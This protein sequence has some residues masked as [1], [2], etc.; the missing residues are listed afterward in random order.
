MSV[1]KIT[2]DLYSVGILNP[3]LRV[4][5][6]I[7]PTE[8]G[9]SYNAYLIKGEKTAL[10]EAVHEDYLDEFID[11]INQVSSLDE[12]DY[13]IVNHTEPDHSGS[14]L[15][16]LEQKPD[17]HIYCTL[18][19]QKY[20]KSMINHEFNSTIVKQGD[21]LDLGN[22]HVL[23]FIPA[24]FLH[25]PDTMFTYDRNFRVLFSCD[26]LSTHF[27]EPTM[28][29]TGVHYQEEYEKSIDHYFHSILHPFKPSVLAGLDKIKD[30]EL[31]FVCTSHG[32]VLTQSIGD[33]M[34]K[35]RQ[36]ATPREDSKPTILIAYASAYGYT[37]LLAEKA[38]EALIG[39][40]YSADCVDMA[41]T[42]PAL[43]AQ[44]INECSALIIGSNTIN[45]D[46]A[47]PV[48]DLLSSIDAINSG[49]KPAG[50]FGSYGW[51]GEAI[52][53]IKNRLEHLRFKFVGDGFR[54]NFRPTDD[55]LKAV[56]NYVLSIAAE[57]KQ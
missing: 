15:K 56:G 57:I 19:A 55:D 50:A 11:N 47:K 43:M 46:A 24:P 37:K 53:M 52:P 51:S 48:W 3:A 23:E 30:L 32:P 17:L 41:Q 12:I 26:F 27:C 31:D 14:I 20:L 29:D 25:W 49:K 36:W 45:R 33:V 6:I 21:T 10:V 18:A 38:Y 54:V 44:K 34:E 8:Y 13:L 39:A 42:D 7:M 35:Y 1:K 22:G 40:G 28:L 16:L 2:N 5:D 4:F 9:T